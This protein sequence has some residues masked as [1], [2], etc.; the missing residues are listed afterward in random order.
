MAKL[1]GGRGQNKG[2]REGDCQKVAGGSGM[3][4][5]ENRGGLGSGRA[6]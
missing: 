4:L 1:G 2:E 5:E 3:A 6:E